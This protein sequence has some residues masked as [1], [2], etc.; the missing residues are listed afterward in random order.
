MY[1]YCKAI[2]YFLEEYSKDHHCLLCRNAIIIIAF[3]IQP[4]QSLKTHTG[5]PWRQVLITI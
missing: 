1:N 5:K 2:Q 4:M 3:T